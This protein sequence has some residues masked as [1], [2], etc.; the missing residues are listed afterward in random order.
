[1][2]V[3]DDRERERFSQDTGRWAGKVGLLAIGLFLLVPVW[4][5]LDWLI[6]LL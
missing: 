6:G 5:L 1:M 4:M 2:S 3:R